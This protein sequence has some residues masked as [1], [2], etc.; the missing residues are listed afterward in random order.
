MRP[1][2]RMHSATLAG[3]PQRLQV[4]LAFLDRAGARGAT[5]REIRVGCGVEAV[6]AAIDELRDNGVG[7]PP[8]RPE[9][10]GGRRKQYVYRLAK[11]AP[12]EPDGGPLRQGNL[13]GEVG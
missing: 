6:S 1:T 13:F 10:R 2:G 7:I 5:A 9:D 12:A 11:Y 8:A 4:L 3:S